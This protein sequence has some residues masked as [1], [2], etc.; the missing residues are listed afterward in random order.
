MT[1]VGRSILLYVQPA[2]AADKSVDYCILPREL[3]LPKYETMNNSSWNV[4]VRSSFPLRYL[5]IISSAKG[6]IG[7]GGSSKL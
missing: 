3:V 1:E 6:Y 4:H 5:E 7:R 2:P